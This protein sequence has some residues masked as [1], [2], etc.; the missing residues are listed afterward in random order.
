MSRPC[1]RPGCWVTVIVD[2]RP[3]CRFD[4]ALV[5]QPLRDAWTSAYDHG[6]GLGSPALLAAKDAMIRAAERA[7]Q[8]LDH[9]TR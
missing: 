7:L 6:R 8:P 1:K 9:L 4:M 3:M 2:D 5:P